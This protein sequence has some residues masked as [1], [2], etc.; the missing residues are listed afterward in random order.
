VIERATT[1]GK[2]DSIVWHDTI[3]VHSCINVEVYADVCVL[4][5][6][7]PIQSCE[8]L[9]IACDN[10]EMSSDDALSIRRCRRHEYKDRLCNS[11][12]AELDTLLSECNAEHIHVR[13][14]DSCAE[15]HP[16][17]I[18]I[19]LDHCDNG[20]PIGNAAKGCNVLF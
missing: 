8:N 15:F 10:I 11:S 17:S 19:R 20:S 12:S 4:L 1:L 16:M 18:R 5:L 3:T 7:A 6:C 9:Q 14:K 13:L 2:A